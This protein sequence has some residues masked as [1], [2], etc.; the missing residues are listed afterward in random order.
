MAVSVPPALLSAMYQDQLLAE[1]R[2]PCNRRQMADATTRAERSNPMCGDALCVM[3]LEA[4]AQLAD[5]S[6]TGHGCSLAIAS[7]SLLTQV[8]WRRR[9]RDALAM[10][11]AVEAMLAG[12]SPHDGA[13]ASALEPLRGVA[14]FP[15]RHGCVMMPWLALREALE[16]SLLD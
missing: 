1:Y 6:F 12:S 11:T 5:V 4:D 9:R 7:A 8:V 16:P 3:V 14:P 10:V 13:W 15:A 2:A